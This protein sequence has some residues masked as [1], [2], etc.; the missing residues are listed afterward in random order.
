M[1]KTKY[2]EERPG[3]KSSTRLNSFILLMFTMAFDVMLA[4]TPGFVIGY[5]FVL[6]NLVMLT[7]VF[8][9]KQL[10]KVVEAKI[11][12]GTPNGG[13]NY[14]DWEES[15]QIQITRKP[16]ADIDLNAPA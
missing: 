5:N 3:V 9:P 1:E 13:R 11:F 10:Q 14:Q 2:F 16:P 7:G 4:L 15:Q 12:Q 8:A 6:L